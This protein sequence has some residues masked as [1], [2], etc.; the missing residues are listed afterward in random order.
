MYAEY[1]KDLKRPK[2]VDYIKNHNSFNFEGLN[3]KTFGIMD[4]KTGRPL[5]TDL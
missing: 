2:H 1:A 5:K 4:K 3:K